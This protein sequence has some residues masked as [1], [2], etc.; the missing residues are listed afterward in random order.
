[1][2][3]SRK[4]RVATSASVEFVNARKKRKVLFKKLKEAKEGSFK[5][6][7]NNDHFEVLN[8]NIAKHFNRLNGKFL[9]LA[10]TATWYDTINSE[11]SEKLTKLYSE[12]GC[13]VPQSTI[14]SVCSSEEELLFLPEYLLLSNGLVMKKRSSPKVL[15]YPRFAKF[16]YDD[17]YSKLLL[18][19]PLKSEEELVT[20]DLRELISQTND[21]N[22][23]LVEEIER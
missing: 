8:S 22:V 10:E 13:E 23:N 2:F 20:G 6:E 16:S 5:S 11:E 7:D 12:T 17:S 3:D 9:V 14:E 18:F 1:M 19:Y 15:V 4:K 21:D